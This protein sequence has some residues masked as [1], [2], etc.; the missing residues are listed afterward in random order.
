MDADD[1]VNYGAIGVVIGHEISHGFDDQGAQFD[2]QGRLQ[3]WWTDGGPQEVPGR[4]ASAWSTSSRA[5][6]S[7]PASTT[8]ASWCSASRIGDLGGREASR[9]AP[10]RSRARASRPQPTID[11]FTPEQQFFIAW[12][13]FRGDAIRPETQRLMVQSDPHPIGKVPGDRAALATCPS[14]AHAFS[15]PADAPMVR[16][17]GEA[18]RGLVIWEGRAAGRGTR[19]RGRQASVSP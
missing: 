16:P 17:A 5:T 11:G 6:S 4:A 14:S 1:A 3:N 10:S 19:P 12:G 2:A 13:Q 18:V 7:S 9:T 15:C 8:T